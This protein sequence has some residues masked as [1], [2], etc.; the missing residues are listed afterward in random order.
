MAPNQQFTFEDYWTSKRPHKSLVQVIK[1]GF[2]LCAQIMD[3]V[4][5]KDGLELWHVDTSIGSLFVTPKNTRS[6]GGSDCSCACAIS[7]RQE[8]LQ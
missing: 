8:V 2:V 6:C 4:T 1:N 3:A 5:T 7:K